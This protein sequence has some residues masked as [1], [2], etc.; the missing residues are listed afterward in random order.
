MQYIQKGSDV[1][2][3]E[4]VTKLPNFIGRTDIT[5][6]DLPGS[7]T[8][9]PDYSF[10]IQNLQEVIIRG[11]I[12]KIGKDLTYQNRLVHVYQNLASKEFVKDRYIHLNYIQFL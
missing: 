11:I 5:K 6:L 2:V 8:E 12:T 1:A 4:G 9:L 10:C 3:K 7:I